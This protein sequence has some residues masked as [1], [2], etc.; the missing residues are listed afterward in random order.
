MKKVYIKLFLA[1]FCIIN[2]HAQSIQVTNLNPDG[3]GSNPAH[4]TVF[5][6]DLFFMANN[7]TIGYELYKHNAMTNTTTLVQ[8]ITP[9]SSYSSSDLESTIEYNGSL[10]LVISSQ[11]YKYE[12]SSETLS[13]IPNIYVIGEMIIYN[14]KIYMNG[15]ENATT[16]YELYSYDS[17]TNTVDLVSDINNFNGEGSS[18]NE[19][20]LFNNKLYFSAK[21]VVVGKELFEFDAGTGITRLVENI[22]T[23]NQNNGDGT[24][25]DFTVYNNELYFGAFQE[26]VGYELFKYDPIADDVVLVADILPGN[27]QSSLKDLFVHNNKLYYQAKN[28]VDTG[29][30]FHS[31]DAATGEDTL[32]RDLRTGQQSSSPN[33]F[34]SFNGRLF[35]KAT[36]PNLGL[37]ALYAY[38]DDTDVLTELAP[39]GFNSI[40]VDDIVEMDNKLYLG[41]RTDNSA[42][43]QEL[44]VYDDVTVTLVEDIYPGYSASFPELLTIYN[45]ELY[46]KAQNATSGFALFKYNPNTLSVD[47]FSNDI[48]VKHYDNAIHIKDNTNKINTKIYNTLGQLVLQSNANKITTTTLKSGVYFALLT[49]DNTTKT[50]K[51]IK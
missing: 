44:Y 31:F 9:G 12:S 41:G 36:N 17:V 4:L 16:D 10:Y 34:F 18:P 3:H 25:R 7:G 46:F 8:D 50:L 29:V 42:L 47:K 5:G 13:L 6:D 45:N 15:Y 20:I 21:T 28:S 26:A 1:C 27:Y 19:F 51:F 22:N 11:L 23:S 14:N 39:T 37:N 30:E 49:K 35:F 24:P 38:N 48:A 2:V 40:Y 43:G 32:V 33:S